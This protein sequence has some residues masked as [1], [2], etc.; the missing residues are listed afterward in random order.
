MT[1][2]LNPC[3]QLSSTK[4]YIAIQ[5]WKYVSNYTYILLI[6]GFYNKNI[7][8]KIKAKFGLK[9]HSWQISM[10]ANITYYK[11]DIFVIASINVGKNLTY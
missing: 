6:L 2:R 7:S 4:Q 11:K 3:F 9:S 8:A 10:I 1:I 5:V